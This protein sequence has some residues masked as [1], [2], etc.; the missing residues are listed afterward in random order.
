MVKG[1]KI[2]FFDLETLPN[3][4]E[5]LKVWNQM[6]DYP[7][8]S[9]KADISTI[10]CFGYMWIGEKKASCKSLWDFKAWN[11]NVNNDLPLIKFAHSV[12]SKADVIVTHN[13]ARFDYPFLNTRIQYHR[14]RGHKDLT[15]IPK[16]PHVDT[17]RILKRNF[18]L[19]NNRLNTAGK[20]LKQGEKLKHSGWDLW[21]DVHNKDQKAMNKMVKYCKQDVKL[22]SQVFNEIRSVAKELPN[23]NL[24]TDKP[25][26]PRCGSHALQSRGSGVTISKR[27]QRYQCTD[28][29]HW[30]QSDKNLLLKGL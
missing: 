8:R 16:I 10:I 26:C 5:G 20:F 23:M 27:V 28:C 21:V 14:S 25:A 1:P 2:L 3:L 4:Q 29:G 9:L 7:G 22:L 11:K 18:F 17:C 12:I 6:S 30:S 24:F 15:L 13:G 19:F